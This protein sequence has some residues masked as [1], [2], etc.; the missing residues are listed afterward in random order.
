PDAMAERSETWDIPGNR[1]LTA[2]DRLRRTEAV[3]LPFHAAV[4]AQVARLLALG[5]V[6]AVVTVHS[7][8]P[9]WFGQPR[10]VEL[11]VIHDADPGLAL[12]V[13]AAARRRTRLKVELNAPYSAA[14]GVTHSL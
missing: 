12:A 14:D 7:F 4:A 1:G 13:L 3:Y 8:T 10:A 11:G 6:P 9:V 5:T 2:A